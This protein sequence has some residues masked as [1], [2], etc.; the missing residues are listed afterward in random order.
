MSHANF[1][2]PALQQILDKLETIDSKIESVESKN[3]LEE[4][5]LSNKEVA[6]ILRVTPRTLQNYRDNG[7]IPFSQV[8]S[9]IYY[10]SSEIEE[11]LNRHYVKSFADKNRGGQ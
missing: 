6:S 1:E 7:L 8:G 4:D 11:H 5:W 3:S 10:K 9:K 2:I